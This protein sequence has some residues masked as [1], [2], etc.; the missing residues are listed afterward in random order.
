M[1]DCLPDIEY[2]MSMSS[3]TAHTLLKA[4]DLLMRLKLGQYKEICFDLLDVCKPDFC[5]RRDNAEV[6]LKL[7]FDTMFAGK[8]PG[9]YKDDEWYRLYNI[10]QSLRYQIH[11]AE[12]PEST[13]VDS[14]PPCVTGGQP[15]PECSF[16]KTEKKVKT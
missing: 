7:A 14:Y 12:H 4:V 13:G 15:L 11:L 9:T 10:L 3:A 5:I 2:T 8:E 16:C 1:K 6:Y